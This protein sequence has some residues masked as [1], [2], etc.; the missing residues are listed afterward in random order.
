MRNKKANP[1]VLQCLS[2]ATS[3]MARSDWFTTSTNTN[4]AES[5]HAHSQR[6]GVHLSLVS[7]IERARKLD[8]RF[9]E[10]ESAVRTMG[11]QDKYGNN[12]ASGKNQKNISR[13]QNVKQKKDNLNPELKLRDE[14]MKRSQKMVND[15]FS[16]QLVEKLLEAELKVLTE[17]K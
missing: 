16:V 1:W 12:S 6:D 8:E 5:A 17:D 4:I 13:A 11:I 15:G 3:K 7:A 14:L 10:T 9:L 2:I